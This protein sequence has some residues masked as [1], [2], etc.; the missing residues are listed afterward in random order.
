MTEKFYK[1]VWKNTPYRK[2]MKG[3]TCKILKRYFS[4]KDQELARKEIEKLIDPNLPLLCDHYMRL[5][6]KHKRICKVQF[7]DNEKIEYVEAGSL[8]SEKKYIKSHEINSE[9]KDIV[10]NLEG[11]FVY[12]FKLNS[13]YK[14]GRTKIGPRKRLL[15]LQ[16]ASPYKITEIF[17]CYCS[18]FEWK[19]ETLK[20]LLDIRKKRGEW[21]KINEDE[22]YFIKNFIQ[23]KTNDMRSMKHAENSLKY[24]LTYN[25]NSEDWKK[26]RNEWDLQT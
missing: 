8:W 4:K 19:E 24:N 2:S 25:I 23:L 16:S 12:I 11:G 10:D 22:L 6:D 21:Y 3:R 15:E 18:D 20:E 13:Y 1:Y 14:I 7:I 9:K 26:L 17:S 5:L